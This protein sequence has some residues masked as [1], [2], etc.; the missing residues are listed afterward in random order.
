MLAVVLGAGK[1]GR[2]FLGELLYQGGWEIAFVEP[3][4]EVVEALN[5]RGEYEIEFVDGERKT[6]KGVRASGSP[7]GLIETAG[8]LFTSVGVR[9][10]AEAGRLIAPGIQ[11]RNGRPLNILICENDL[12]ADRILREAVGLSDASVGYCRCVVSRMVFEELPGDPPVPRAE[13]YPYL[14]VDA[15]AIVGELPSV[16][17]LTLASPFEGFARRKLY[18]HNGVH[19]I[20]A[21]LGAERGLIYIHQAMADPVIGSLARQASQSLQDALLAAYSFD[22]IEM[23]SHAEDLLSR[24]ADPL[25][26]DPIERAAADP[27]RK[28]GEKD[29]LLGA[30][31]F[32]SEHDQ[33][34]TPFD[35]AIQA[36]KQYAER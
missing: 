2:G 22:S 29:R 19:A 32:L 16:P 11:A 25:L 6:I 5:R 20:L 31:R 10:L 36:A 23:R 17:G 3:R 26:R 18:L 24:F 28:L 34:P 30:R 14:P 35:L 27:L 15:D 7:Q 8:L 21:Y 9:N 1:I 12:H 33:D 13:R 4:K